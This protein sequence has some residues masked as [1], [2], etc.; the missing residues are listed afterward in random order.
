MSDRTMASNRVTFRIPDSL[1]KKLRNRVVQC[2]TSESELVRKALESYLSDASE[3]RSA[4][5]VAGELGLVGCYKGGPKDLSTNS[6]HLKGF[7]QS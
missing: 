4:L 6:R 1:E 3:G 5:E 7:G 2:G